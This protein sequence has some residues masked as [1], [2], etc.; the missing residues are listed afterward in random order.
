M[1]EEVEGAVDAG[2]VI[3]LAA[4]SAAMATA[5]SDEAVTGFIGGCNEVG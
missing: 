3:V 5:V 2:G 4:A 1:V